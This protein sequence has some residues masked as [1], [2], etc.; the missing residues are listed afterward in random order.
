MIVQGRGFWGVVL[1]LSGCSQEVGE[2]PANQTGPSEAR[3]TGSVEAS[4]DP[5]QA[6]YDQSRALRTATRREE[7]VRLV[8]ALALTGEERE[9]TLAAFEQ[10]IQASNRLSAY[11]R[12][13]RGIRTREMVERAERGDRELAEALRLASPAFLN[14]AV[15]SAIGAEKFVHYLEARQQ[16]VAQLPRTRR[17][18]LA[19]QSPVV[20]GDDR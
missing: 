3:G 11:R 1:L 18:D 4:A 13:H 20:K 6:L 10:Q 8:D 17:R 16:R 19:A 12:Q 2:V 15:K 9:R 5:Q 7:A 14:E